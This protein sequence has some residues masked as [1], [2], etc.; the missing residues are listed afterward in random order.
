VGAALVAGVASVLDVASALGMASVLGVVALQCSCHDGGGTG[1]MG[2]GWRAS[3]VNCRDV[4]ICWVS[5]R[6]RVS[7]A[8]GTHGP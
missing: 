3:Q 4:C 6:D 2:S 5:E 7:W 1:V 8:E